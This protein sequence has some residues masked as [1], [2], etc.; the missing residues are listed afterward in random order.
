MALAQE[1][2]AWRNQP[3]TPCP[4]LP[5]VLVSLS[6]VL[7][8]FIAFSPT[9]DNDF[10][11][12]DDE[13]NIVNNPHLHGRGLVQLKWAWTT[14]RLAVYQPLAW[15]LFSA[16]SLFWKLDPWGYHL[17]SILLH[18]ANAVVLYLLTLTLLVRCRPGA[19][20]HNPSSCVMSAGVAT[21]LFMVHPMRVEAVAWVSCQPYLPCAFFSMLAVLAYLHAFPSDLQPRQCWLAA[22]LVLF[23]QPCYFMRLPSVSRSFFSFWTFIRCGV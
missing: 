7:I 4:Y 11:N 5:G 23:L 10:V 20:R 2:N 3:S 21:A 17:T 8:V 9:L 16:Q 22:A 13:V 18:A 15:M 19:W 14:F 1:K 12:W 6:L